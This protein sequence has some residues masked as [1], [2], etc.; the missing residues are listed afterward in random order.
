MTAPTIKIAVREKSGKASVFKVQHEQIQTAEQ[1]IELTRQEFP[2]ARVVL[3]TV[4]AVA[5]VVE[6]DAA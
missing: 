4:P 6:V 5:A 1:A 2:D 3:A